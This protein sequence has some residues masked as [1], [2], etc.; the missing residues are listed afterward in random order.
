M[1]VLVAAWRQIGEAGAS[2]AAHLHG[3]DLAVDRDP[4][5]GGW[6]W[7]VS[8]PGG[9]ALAT[10]VTASRLAAQRA[11]EDEATAVHPPTDELLGRLLR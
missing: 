2:F 11:A 5:A 8:T 9:A 1:T 7:Q 6:R 4:A 10:G 3:R